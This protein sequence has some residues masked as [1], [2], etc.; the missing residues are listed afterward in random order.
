MDRGCNGPDGATLQRAMEPEA[1]M[2]RIK[3]DYSG[4]D[5]R[6]GFRVLVDRLWPRGV[7]KA[8]AA[9]GQWAKEIAPSSALRTWFGHDPERFREFRARYRQELR[10]AGAREIL[11]DLAG[12]AA[13]GTV[14]LVYGARDETCNGAVVLQEVLHAMA[15]KGA[16]LPRRRRAAP[17]PAGPAPKGASGRRGG[18]GAPRSRTGGSPATERSTCA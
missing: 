9:L 13:H 5:S 7:M 8:E 15:V 17:D 16:G 6:D 1:A 12:K 3:R 18:G 2:V 10:G 11:Q 4:A 14:T